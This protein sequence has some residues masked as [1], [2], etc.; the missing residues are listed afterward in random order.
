MPLDAPPTAAE[1]GCGKLAIGVLRVQIIG[2]ALGV[3]S[4]LTALRASA[5]DDARVRLRQTA[6]RVTI[7]RD[8]WGIAHIHGHFDAQAVFGM[9]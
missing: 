6:S 5:A 3:I 1:D 9:A 7:T 2:L 8:D 4:L